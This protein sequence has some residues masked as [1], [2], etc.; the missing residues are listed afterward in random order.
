MSP[1]VVLLRLL[2][3]VLLTLAGGVV[4]PATAS[5]SGD[6]IAVR[7]STRGRCPPGCW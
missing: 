1:M 2:A 3:V 6:P 7:G 4:T 5:G